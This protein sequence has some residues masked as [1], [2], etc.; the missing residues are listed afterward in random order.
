MQVD[1][2]SRAMSLDDHAF[3]KL[4]KSVFRLSQYGLRGLNKGKILLQGHA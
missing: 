4:E 3:L 2:S 1:T